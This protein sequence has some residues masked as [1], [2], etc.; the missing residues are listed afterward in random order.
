MQDTNNDATKTVDSINED[1]MVIETLFARQSIMM[2][3]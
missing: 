2:D 3:E 1:G